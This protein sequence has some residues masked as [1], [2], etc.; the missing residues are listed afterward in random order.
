MFFPCVDTVNL[1]TSVAV[2]LCL[3]LQLFTNLHSFNCRNG[4]LEEHVQAVGNKESKKSNTRKTRK[5]PVNASA[6]KKQKAASA[7]KKQKAAS[8]RKKQKA[9]SGLEPPAPIAK[10]TFAF[11]RNTMVSAHTNMA[12][13]QQA[14]NKPVSSGDGN[15]GA[16]E[17]HNSSTITSGENLP[18]TMQIEEVFMRPNVYVAPGAYGTPQIVALVNV[19]E[20]TLPSQLEDTEAETNNTLKIVDVFSA[21]EM[22]STSTPEFGTSTLQSFSKWNWHSS[23][24][25]EDQS[26]SLPSL[27][28]SIQ[29]S[30]T[31]PS[32][33]RNWHTPVP[34]N[35]PHK[36]SIEKEEVVD[37]GSTLNHVTLP[38]E[39][40]EVLVV[41][42]V[43][44]NKEAI[45]QHWE[46]CPSGFLCKYCNKQY[47][48]LNKCE[49]HIRIHLGVKPYECQ[50]CKHR[51]HKK[52]MLNEHYAFHTGKKLYQCK[53]CDKSF[54]YRKNFKSHA[55]CHVEEFNSRYF[56]EICNKNFQLQFDY[57]SHKTSKHVIVESQMTEEEMRE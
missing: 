10:E 3:K 35:S 4:V 31:N 13:S 21:H 9:S 47:R 39:E 28:C 24:P 43:K 34:V 33:I 15:H 23:S 22:P 29:S 20:H 17:V 14:V 32:T 50:I 57:W 5:P 1:V 44:A 19:Q 16:S 11:Q 7:R 52:R 46:R 26:N 27:A 8:A 36:S 55:E 40:D 18:E 53:K 48:S 56:C 49:N 41:E 25:T 45:A 6:R 38:E 2:L 37:S 51:Y 54:R 30:S 12:V 42:I